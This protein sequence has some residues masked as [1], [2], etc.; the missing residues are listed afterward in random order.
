MAK[1]IKLLWIA[2]SLAITISVISLYSAMSKNER[3]PTSSSTA[4]DIQFNDIQAQIKQLTSLVEAMKV[5][6]N[7]IAPSARPNEDM[8]I[9]IDELVVINDRLDTLERIANST[10]ATTVSDEDSGD[11]QTYA[12]QT[13][14]AEEYIAKVDAKHYTQEPGD[15]AWAEPVLDYI[16]YNVDAGALDGVSVNEIDCG[17]ETC[18]IDISVKD[19]TQGEEL[20]GRILDKVNWDSQHILSIKDDKFLIYLSASEQPLI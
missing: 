7:K 20:S 8:S 2:L 16:H 19:A 14:S 3:D 18:K 5:S 6:N 17:S 13:V 1:D 9:L 10:I 4:T 11:A 12:I 15:N